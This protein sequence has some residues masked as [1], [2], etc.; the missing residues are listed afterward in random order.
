MSK[1]IDEAEIA[2]VIN[3]LADRISAERKSE[4][5]YEDMFKASEGGIRPLLSKANMEITRVLLSCFD[6][7]KE[8]F[9]VNDANQLW[10]D[11]KLLPHMMR[12]TRRDISEAEGSCCEADKTRE[13]VAQHFLQYLTKK[14]A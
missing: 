12:E 11:L 14:D 4:Q 7:I 13:I 10:S 1:P 6:V 8:R 5:P 3:K 9:E 2:S